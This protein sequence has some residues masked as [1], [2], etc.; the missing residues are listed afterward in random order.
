[1]TREE[2]SV[3]S[4]FYADPHKQPLKATSPGAGG[5][6]RRH[7]A[8]NASSKHLLSERLFRRFGGLAG[9]SAHPPLCLPTAGSPFRPRKKRAAFAYTSTRGPLLE[10]V[11]EHLRTRKRLR[12]AVSPSR[13][14]LAGWK[15]L[16]KAAGGNL[17]WV[18]VDGLVERLRARQR[19]LRDRTNPGGGAAG[20]RGHG[21]S[22]SPDPARRHG[23]GHRRRD[24]LPHAPEGRFRGVVRSHCGC[25]TAI[26]VASCASYG[27]PNWEKRV[28]RVGPGCYTAPLLQRPYAHGARWTGVRRAS[29]GGIRRCWKRR[30]RQGTR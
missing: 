3:S 28:G 14:T 9:G 1:M 4:L 24:W 10:A 12:V 13:L 23:T 17:K 21:G 16:Q 26:G 6:R 11:G 7:V 15:T 19:R 2:T 5:R 22:D 27:A 30:R 25:G 29:G 8:R 18:A 20:L